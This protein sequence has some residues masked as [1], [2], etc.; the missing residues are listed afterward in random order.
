MF[1]GIWVFVFIDKL[2]IFIITYISVFDEI[3]IIIIN[4]VANKLHGTS[5]FTIAREG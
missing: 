2:Y 5:S 3:K 4:W 1:F